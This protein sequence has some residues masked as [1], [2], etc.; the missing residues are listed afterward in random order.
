MARSKTTKRALVASACATLMCI[1]ML[2]GT[3]FAWFTDTASTSV[4]KI[5]SGTLNVGLEMLTQDEGESTATWKTAEGKSIE[6]VKAADG[7]A[8]EVLWE[9]GCT[10]ELPKLRVVNNGNLALK[11]KVV[12]TGIKGDAKL[13]EAIEW[14][15]KLDD[16]DYVVD[17]EHSLAAKT[18]T[19]TD[20][21]VFT[22]SGHMKEEAGNEYQGKSIEGIS[23]TVYATQDTVEY[24]SYTNTYD[25]SS[26]YP[27]IP[28]INVDITKTASVNDSSALTSAVAMSG[29]TIPAG[30]V[31]YTSHSKTDSDKL[32]TTAI[33]GGKLNEKIETTSASANALT[34]SINYTYSQEGAT[35]GT[36]IKAFSEA[37]THTI[38]LSKG[39]ASVTV[40]HGENAMTAGSSAT[41]LN[42]GEY[43]YDASTG[44]LTI[45]SSTYSDFKIEITHGFVAATDG[46]GYK[47][48]AEAIDAAKDNG[49][50]KLLDA[51]TVSETIEFDKSLTLDLNGTTLTVDVTDKSADGFVV[52][53]GASLTLANSIANHGTFLF[54]SDSISND[55]IYV[56]NTVA[57]KTASLTVQNPV[58]IEMQG[59]FNSAIHTYASAGESKLTVEDGTLIDI[60]TTAQMKAVQLDQ[61]ST[62]TMNG[63]E[64]KMTGKFDKYSTNNDAVGVLL[65][66]NNGKQDSI[67]FVMN[68]GKLTVGGTN[69][70]AQGIQVG[71]VNGYSENV[72]VVINDGEICA[73]SNDGGA[74]YAFTA[75]KK[76]YATF[77]MNGGAVSG[78]LTALSTDAW[79][80]SVN[81]TVTGGTFSVD[82][83]TYVDT[84][85][86]NVTN[87]DGVWT[88]TKA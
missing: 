24:D 66:G 76:D 8:Q 43:Y 81:L 17:A 73:G 10:Y 48:L 4:N 55:G 79:G 29:S 70:F 88:V 31:L 53:S 21:D 46:Q 62:G 41:A 57:D 2:I 71:M 9:P 3:T 27:L 52:N 54:K 35:E 23:I 1:A 15:M 75:Y 77:T 38:P 67:H 72:S 85:K 78:T 60:T 64:I 58:H 82:P 42:D 51:T 59:K 56:Y 13:N 49:T 47:T 87:S 44:T 86:Y 7:S 25:I 83:S 6:F 84:T 11:Y 22:I 12:I 28:N 37:I 16:S 18:E 34:V 30:T 33:S 61:S 14:T 36:A 26:M 65:Y 74:S 32:T 40:T 63:G 50:V 69:A 80:N 68:G 20:S 5:Q 39:L 19:A 45:K